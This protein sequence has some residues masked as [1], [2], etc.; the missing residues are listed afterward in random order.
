MEQAD[1]IYNAIVNLDTTILNDYI[2][3]GGMSGRV[4]KMK[5]WIKFRFPRDV[6]PWDKL[7]GE[8]K[9]KYE[10]EI[11]SDDNDVFVRID[12]DYA[13]TSDVAV[14]ASYFLKITER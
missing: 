1:L 9:R 12:N 3:D 8:I 10:I 4:G 11:L 5:R 14:P 13:I 2:V 6:F 7:T